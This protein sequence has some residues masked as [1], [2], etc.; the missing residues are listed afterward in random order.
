[1]VIYEGVLAEHR[2]FN[3]TEIGI[4]QTLWEIHN[5]KFMMVLD[6]LKWYTYKW[7]TLAGGAKHICSLPRIMLFSREDVLVGWV[8]KTNCHLPGI[9][10]YLIRI[11]GVVLISLFFFFFLIEG[12]GPR[13]KVGALHSEKL[14]VQ[15]MNIKVCFF[16]IN[17]L[18]NVLNVH[19]LWA[20]KLIKM[21]V[22]MLCCCCCFVAK[23]CPALLLLSWKNNC[24]RQRY[25]E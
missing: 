8:N 23:S 10:D 25:T 1:M 2:Q 4:T 24:F 7:D 18:K 22:I 13:V 20:V 17:S 15:V 5:K 3:R 16:L 6:Y 12:A 19:C 9:K 14:V 11:I 21:Y